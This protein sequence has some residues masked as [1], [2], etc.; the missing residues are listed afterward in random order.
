MG[1]SIGTTNSSV[2]TLNMSPSIT[3][4]FIGATPIWGRSATLSVGAIGNGTL[5]YQWYVNGQPISG[6]VYPQLNFSSIQLTNSGFY[7]VVITSP[8]GNVTNTA[9]QVSV[10]PAVV[11]LAFYPGLTINGAFGNSY[12]IQRSTDLSNTNNWRTVSSLTMYQPV[13][14]W[15]DTSVDATSPFNNMYFYQLIPQ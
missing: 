5:S 4:P 8:Y 1:S 3:S 10:S 2:A 6:A 15:I 9:Y 14:L 11:T 12:I 13:S 7:S